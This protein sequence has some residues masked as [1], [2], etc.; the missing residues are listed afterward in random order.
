MLNCYEIGYY[1]YNSVFIMQ[2]M[3]CIS[4]A[5]SRNDL[6]EENMTKVIAL[7]NAWMVF[8]FIMFLLLVKICALIE[9]SLLKF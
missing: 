5:M 1:I 2:F 8:S 6:Y 7:N 9:I 3:W 4:Q